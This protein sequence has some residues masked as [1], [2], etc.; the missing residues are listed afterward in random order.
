LIAGM[1]WFG[2]P[3]RPAPSAADPVRPAP[4]PAAAQGAGQVEPQTPPPAPTP[5]PP[6]TG[7]KPQ[8]SPA[9]AS[10]AAVPPDAG[11]PV[12]FDNVRLLAVNGRRTSATDVVLTFEGDRL[13]AT[14]RAAT[15]PLASLPYR[16]I[17]AA[18]YVFAANP[19]WSPNHPAPAGSIDVPGIFGRRRHWFVVQTGEA[20]AILQLDGRNWSDVLQTFETRTGVGVSRPP[21][22]G[23][24]P[25]AAQAGL[26][27]R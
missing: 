7:A 20:Y 13:A 26:P 4:E 17:A 2:L 15:A 14:S 10:P 22:R 11:A 16:G 19:R 18:T 6:P 1:L 21:A 8:P 9:A 24:S 27:N 12:R 5:T 25:R 23:G 3:A